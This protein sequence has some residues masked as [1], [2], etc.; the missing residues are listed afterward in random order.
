M[1]VVDQAVDLIRI[2]EG[3]AHELPEGGYRKLRDAA[4]RDKTCR[5]CTK[6]PPDFD[7]SHNASVVVRTARRR[8]ACC[9]CITA[10]GGRREHLARSIIVSFLFLSFSPNSCV[11]HHQPLHGFDVIPAPVIVRSGPSLH[12][13]RARSR[14]RGAG[15]KGTVCFPSFCT[16]Q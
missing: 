2:A 14:G 15:G 8:T 11:S 13:S 7:L 3:C 9:P 5:S 12:I 10:Y 1:N 4:S 16:V 6:Q